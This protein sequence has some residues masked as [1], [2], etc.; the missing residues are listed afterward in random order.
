MLMNI[1]SLDFWESTFVLLHLTRKPPLVSFLPIF[2]FQNFFYPSSVPAAGIHL[3]RNGHSQGHQDFIQQVHVFWTWAD[4][5]DL[6]T[7][8][9]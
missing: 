8:L 9:P 5:L 7:V 2:P 4:S 6:G 1:S 3:L